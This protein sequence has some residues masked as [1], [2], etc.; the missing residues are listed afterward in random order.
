MLQK[1]HSENSQLYWWPKIQGL[2]IPLPETRIVTGDEAALKVAAA[3]LGYPVFI[4]T[5]YTSLKHSWKNTAYVTAPEDLGPNVTT[6]AMDSHFQGLP[7]NAIIIRKILDLE[8]TFEAFSGNLPI[9]KE[10]RFFIDNDLVCC[11]HP[12]WPEHAIEGQTANPDWK[13]KLK[14]LN[15]ITFHETILLAGY[16]TKVGSVVSGYWSVD[17]AKAKDGT[18]YL[19]DMA[20]GE[21]SFHWADCPSRR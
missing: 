14:Q 18:W 1:D 15:E 6:L 21:D 17:F 13:A 12:Y 11:H 3:E 16:A 9:H 4:R 2:G 19:L 7:V 10:Q 5:D 8:T 20:V